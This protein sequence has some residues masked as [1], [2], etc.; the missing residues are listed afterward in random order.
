MQYRI[1][2]LVLAIA[3]FLLPACD[4][5]P[6]GTGVIPGTEAPD[7]AAGPDGSASDAGHVEL[8]ESPPGTPPS[9][10]TPTVNLYTFNTGLIN[11][12]LVKA[13]A[14]RRPLIVEAIKRSDADVICLQEV[15]TSFG[16]PEG[17]WADIKDEFPYATWRWTSPDDTILG[18][19]L[20][21]ASRHPLYRARSLAYEAMNEG[22]IVDRA[23]VAADVLTDAAY[24]TVMCTHLQAGL[25]A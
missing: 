2:G 10:V 19:G 15:F 3:S 20:L 18:P 25:G 1:S 22:S 24:F 14:E 8:P 9:G 6:T 12:N 23:L 13:P 5:G 4:S 11:E 17:L 16:G 21:I 7:A